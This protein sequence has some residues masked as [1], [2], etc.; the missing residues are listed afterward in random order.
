MNTQTK[1][2]RRRFSEKE[3]VTMA[4]YE[5]V[6]TFT[7]ICSAEIPYSY[8][9][10]SCGKE[11]SGMI[12]LTGKSETARRSRH[13]ENLHLSDMENATLGGDALDKLRAELYICRKR[14][15][16]GDYSMLKSVSKCP[17]CGT[18]QLWASSVKRGVILL[19]HGLC[20]A[21]ITVALMI[22]Q[23]EEWKTGD[24]DWSLLGCALMAAILGTVFTVCTVMEFKAFRAAKN[25][26]RQKPELYFDRIKSVWAKELGL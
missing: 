13:A 5:Y 2:L 7:S 4:H 25:Q 18:D 19:I 23:I 21:A 10:G 8:I 22:W 15:R 14:Y 24:K 16:R 11:A 26:S 6:K 3:D 17:H 1:R 20:L 9:C 12:E